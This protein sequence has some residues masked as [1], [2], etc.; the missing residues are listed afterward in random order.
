MKDI[1]TRIDKILTEDATLRS[2]V[3]YLQRKNVP[4]GKE[5]LQAGISEM[6]IRRGYQTEGKWDKLVTYYFQPEVVLG[7]AL[8]PSNA[9]IRELPLVINVYDRISDLNLYDIQERVIALLNDSNL[10]VEGVVHSYGCHYLGQ[11]Q[12]PYYDTDLKCFRMSLRFRV[13]AH[14]LNK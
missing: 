5:G 9:S 14:L 11:I 8:D 2:L 10:T 1:Y 12:S 7:S 13:I 4:I 3:G 6:T